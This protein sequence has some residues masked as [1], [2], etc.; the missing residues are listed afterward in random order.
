MKEMTF[1]L[2]NENSDHEGGNVSAHTAHLVG[3]ALSDPYLSVAAGINAGAGPLHGLAIQGVPVFLSKLLDQFGANATEEQIIDFIWKTLKCGQIIPGCGHAVLR[4]TDPR[5][6]YQHEFAMK[7]LPNDPLFHLASTVYKVAPRILSELGKVRNPE[8]N[9][10]AFTGILLHQFGVKEMNFYTIL[11][12]VSRC[13]G[14]LAQLIWDRA[15]CLPIER[16]KSLST[17]ALKKIVGAK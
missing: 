10:D 17:A 9:A 15:L 3:S 5:H 2:I 8:P 6:I 7:H 1:S 4:K 13:I 12:M 16:P 14:V 11:M